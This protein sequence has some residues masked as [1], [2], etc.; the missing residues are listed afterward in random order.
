MTILTEAKYVGDATEYYPYGETASISIR[1]HLLGSKITVHKVRG[2]DN[3]LPSTKVVY[4]NL[5]DFL[6]DWKDFKR[7]REYSL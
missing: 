4:G 2:R 1:T 5:G 6:R 7:I 3:D